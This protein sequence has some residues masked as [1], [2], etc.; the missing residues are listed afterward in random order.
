MP[1]AWKR[2]VKAHT[3]DADRSSEGIRFLDAAIRGEL[4]A[5]CR[6]AF[7][8]QLACRLLDEAQVLVGMRDP[9]SFRRL[10][11]NSAQ[12]CTVSHAIR[13]AEQIGPGVVQVSEALGYAINEVVQRQFHATEGHLALNFPGQRS[14]LMRRMRT[15][16]S[17]IEVTNL[18]QS[19]VGGN[20]SA[21]PSRR[22]GLGLD[23]HT[24]DGS[25]VAT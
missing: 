14:E 4:A 24:R 22:P 2:V 13:L 15:C 16:L 1:T 3:R 10:A 6:G 17:Q 23:D 11:R 7:L 21:I 9:E 8:K 5:V 20:L 19:A 12:D 25:V 18:V